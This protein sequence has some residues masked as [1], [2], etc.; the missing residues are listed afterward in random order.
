VEKRKILLCRESNSGRPARSQSL[1]QLS[2]PDSY[3]S[4]NNNNNNNNKFS[5]S[6]TEI[7]AAG[8]AGLDIIIQWCWTAISLHSAVFGESNRIWC[9]RNM[10]TLCYVIYDRAVLIILIFI[11]YHLQ[12]LRL[13]AELGGDMM[14]MGERWSAAEDD[15]ERRERKLQQWQSYQG[16]G[17][18]GNVQHSVCF[19]LHSLGGII[20]VALTTGSDIGPCYISRW[21]H[22]S[23]LNTTTSRQRASH[24]VGS[25]PSTACSVWY[26]L[27]VICERFAKEVNGLLPSYVPAG[28]EEDHNNFSLDSISTLTWWGALRVLV[29]LR[30]MLAVA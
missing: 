20:A 21:V 14:I 22:G 25:E 17:T 10:S 6:A 12:Y 1:Y 7:S 30:A 2:Y 4:N 11:A 16:N 28:T 27:P 24:L 15:G 29:T 26:I 9:S 5:F 13:Y 8:H 19:P 23:L 3:N 18:E